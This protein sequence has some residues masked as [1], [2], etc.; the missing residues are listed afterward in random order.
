MTI[1]FDDLQLAYNLLAA[2]IFFGFL[3]VGLGVRMLH[4]GRRRK[5]ARIKRQQADEVAA[6]TT[7]NLMRQRAASFAARSLK[8]TRYGDRRYRDGHFS[9]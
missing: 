4:H 9:G 6:E 5:A 7:D 1:P 3:A 8:T 2:A